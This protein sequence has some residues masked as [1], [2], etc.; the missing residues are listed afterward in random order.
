MPVRAVAP[1]FNRPWHG[2]RD[3]IV[4]PFL[5]ERIQDSALESS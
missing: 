5:F 3:M 1:I 4:Q 2:R